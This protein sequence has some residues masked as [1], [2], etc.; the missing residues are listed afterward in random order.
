M[1]KELLAILLAAKLTVAGGA[2][3]AAPA[4]AK[5]FKPAEPV[6]QRGVYELL[7]WDGISHSRAQTGIGIPEGQKPFC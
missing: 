7:S 3:L 4:P 6:K 5:D 2:F 1:P